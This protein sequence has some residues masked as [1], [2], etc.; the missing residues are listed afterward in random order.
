[1]TDYSYCFSSFFSCFFLL[2]QSYRLQ[3]SYG[4]R[5]ITNVLMASAGVEVEWLRDTGNVPSDNTWKPTH[6][7]GQKHVI[8]LS[9]A[10]MGGEWGISVRKVK[11]ICRVFIPTGDNF[12]TVENYVGLKI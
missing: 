8:H 12:V 5:D 11:F 10:D 1:M 2:E 3:V 7:D 4:N 6:V 9:L